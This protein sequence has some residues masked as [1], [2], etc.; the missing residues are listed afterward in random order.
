MVPS[1]PYCRRG[2]DQLVGE[3]SRS[4]HNNP[5]MGRRKPFCHVHLGGVR[6]G[7]AGNTP[8]FCIVCP[9]FPIPRAVVPQSLQRHGTLTFWIEEPVERLFP[10]QA[11]PIRSSTNFQR[12]SARTPCLRGNS[13][14][15]DHIAQLGHHTPRPCYL[16]IESFRFQ[17]HRPQ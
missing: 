2:K 1:I 16:K 8:A 13:S 7:N 12:R 10:V 14:W 11:W 6:R 17:I 4:F 9:P 15:R 5:S 3:T